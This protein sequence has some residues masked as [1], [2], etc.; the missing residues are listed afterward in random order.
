MFPSDLG[1]HLPYYLPIYFVELFLLCALLL[2]QYLCVK[3]SELDMEIVGCLLSIPAVLTTV[4]FLTWQQ[5][6][7]YAELILSS[8][9]IG[10]QGA[11]MLSALTNRVFN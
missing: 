7:L 10:F 2:L 11:Y 6:V 8:F 3:V 4:Y 5:Y 9:Q 1:S